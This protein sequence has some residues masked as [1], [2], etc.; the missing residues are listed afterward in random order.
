METNLKPIPLD[1]ISLGYLNFRHIVVSKYAWVISVNATYKSKV[2]NV[3][4]QRDKFRW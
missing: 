3:C 1:P 2:D 4:F